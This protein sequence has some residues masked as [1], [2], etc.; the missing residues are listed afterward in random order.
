MKLNGVNW[1]RARCVVVVALIVGVAL[2]VAGALYQTL[3]VRRES[4]RFPPPG[5]LVD[6]GG[7]R[8][9]LICLGEGEPAVIFEPSGFGGALSAEA[10]RVEVA[11]R[12]RVCS[13]DRM[14]MG[15]SD[16]GPSVISAGVLAD[17]LQRL[18]D[19]AELRPPYILVPASISG[20]TVELFA[21]RHPDQI[22]GLVFV[23]AASSDTFER[24]VAS[25]FSA[26]NVKTRME[27][28]A[29][30]LTQVAAR[31]GLLRLIDPFGLRRERSDAAARTMARLYRAE[32][33]G[34]VCAV[35]RGISRSAQ[36]LRDAPPLRNDVPLVVL[37]HDQPVGLL[38]PGLG[39]ETA[40][41]EPEW[42][43]LQQALA[44]RS[45]RGTWRIVPNSGHLIAGSQPH[46]VATTILEM[47]A[48]IRRERAAHE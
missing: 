45:T 14:G 11:A 2:A 30:C 25:R 13:Y 6:V 1:H 28:E 38:P 29:A 32:P 5:R 17:D 42:R 40:A 15:W 27:I 43:G 24:F 35:V 21:R 39:F 31:L 34:T 12:T 47:L 23:D 26:M 37:I 19:R 33:M 46:A 20:L 10:A 4:V 22:A 18:L 44:R 8:L 16:P 9:H 48:Q 41:I 7:R 3:S 36:E